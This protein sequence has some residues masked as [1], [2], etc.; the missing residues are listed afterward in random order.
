VASLEGAK[1]HISIA[2]VGCNDFTIFE[3]HFFDSSIA[4]NGAGKGTVYEP[5]LFESGIFEIGM[6]ERFVFKCPV[7]IRFGLGLFHIR[8]YDGVGGAILF[9]MGGCRALEYKAE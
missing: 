5:Y 9:H 6:V 3:C 7:F 1:F 8:L 2:P 4:K